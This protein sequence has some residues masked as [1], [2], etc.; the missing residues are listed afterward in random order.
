MNNL[1]CETRI[2]APL[3]RGGELV[4]KRKK[5]RKK[6]NDKIKRDVFVFVLFV[7]R[8]PST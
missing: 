1:L 7:F 2:R 8:I 5:R 6:E 3:N 4:K